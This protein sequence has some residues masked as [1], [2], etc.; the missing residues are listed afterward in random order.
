[1]QHQEL[2]PSARP[3]FGSAKTRRSRG[4]SPEYSGLT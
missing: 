1:M 4:T 2:P 3:S